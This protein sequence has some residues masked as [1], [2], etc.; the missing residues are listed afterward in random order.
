MT[1]A[2]ALLDDPEPLVRLAAL[3]RIADLARSDGDALVLADQI[4]SGGFDRDRGLMDAATSAAA[5]HD[6]KILDYLA[7]AQI[8]PSAVVRHADHRLPPCRAPRPGRAG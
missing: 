7:R 5:R 2:G 8:R 6:V 3:L 1:P 4:A